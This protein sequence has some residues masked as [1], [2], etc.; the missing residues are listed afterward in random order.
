[1]WLV[2]LVTFVLPLKHW[3][4]WLRLPIVVVPKVHS[5]V[6]DYFYS[7]VCF[8]FFV[9]VLL[10]FVFSGFFGGRGVVCFFSSRW[11]LYVTDS[12]S[13]ITSQIYECQ[14]VGMRVQVIISPC[15]MIYICDVF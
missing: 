2:T 14:Q 11:F 15:S 12:F 3:F 13:L 8:F 5:W 4:Y 1:M 7:F 6:I 9:V 10:V